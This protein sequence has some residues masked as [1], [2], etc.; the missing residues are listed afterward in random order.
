[1][2]QL[3]IALR[4]LFSKKQTNAI[5]IV[6]Y[7]SMTGMGIGAFAL[8]VVLSV[9]NGFESLVISLYNSFYPSL[10]I[11]PKEGKFFQYNQ[12][13]FYIISKEKGVTAVSKVLEE[14]AYLQFSDRNYLALV[15]GVDSTYDKVTSISKTIQNGSY[16]LQKD[17]YRFAVLG[18]NIASSLNV[19]IDRVIE[20]M[21]INIPRNTTATAFR[22]E[23]VFYSG[24]VIPAAEFSI[25]QEFDSRY[26]FVSLDFLQQLM[27]EE[28][29]LSAYEVLLDP[30]S[31]PDKVKESLG[32]KLGEHFI[33]KTK[34]EQKETLYKIMKMER[35]AVYAIL[36]FIMIIV[37][38]NIIGSLFM[39]VIEK[40]RDISILKSMG[41]TNGDILKIF[42]LEGVLSA[43]V[44]ASIG[45]SLAVII[46]LLQ[47]H[48][49]FV[50]LGGA[51]AT[52]VVDAYPVDLRIGDIL[53]ALFTVIII[54]LPASFLPAWNAAKSVI[55]VKR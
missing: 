43:L 40:K 38:F 55:Q 21:I 22:E 5:N 18:A 35:W 11:A 53:L 3:N 9:F 37:S 47:Q 19:Q 6:N 28:N 4:Y 14:N 13:K 32:K 20:P 33:I 26:V 2:Y 27:G 50:K 31:N 25:Q 45:I 44:G 39:V 30:S 49:G 52:F 17:D 42:T 54:S 48:F 15:K 29:M 23:D 36:S 41:A 46:C 51:N 16:I 1:M 10:Q 24:S 12:N 7:V 8:V 34:Y